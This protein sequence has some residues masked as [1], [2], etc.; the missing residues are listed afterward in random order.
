MCGFIL[1]PW[2]GRKTLIRLFTIIKNVFHKQNGVEGNNQN[3]CLLHASLGRLGG[4]TMIVYA[5]FN[6][7]KIDFVNLPTY[8]DYDHYEDIT[9]A[10]TKNRWFKYSVVCSSYKICVIAYNKI[11]FTEI[12]PSI[13]EYLI[14]IPL[15][16]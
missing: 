1:L 8:G 7:T 10:Y 15:V 4:G 2:K 6:D 13:V 14:S 12:F 5:S 9:N 16:F 11:F 3:S